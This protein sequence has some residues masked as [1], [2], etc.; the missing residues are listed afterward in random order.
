MN[1]IKRH[2]IKKRRNDMEITDIL[3]QETLDAI[4][5]DA[6]ASGI[7]AADVK[8]VLGTLTDDTRAPSRSA[9][10]QGELM[11]LLDDDKDA[12][13]NDIADATGVER[14][15]TGTILMLAAPFLLKYL[16]SSG[17]SN[18]S[19]GSNMSMMLP[20]LMA[21]MGG[22]QQQSSGLGL[23]GSLLGGGQQYQQ[24]QP[25]SLLGALLG[26]GQQY[27]Q[28]QQNSL[29]SSLLGAQP[30]QQSYSHNSTSALL[31][32][33]WAASLS[34]RCRRSRSNRAVFSTCSAE[35]ALSLRYSSLSRAPA[36]AC[37]APCSTSW[38]TTERKQIL[39]KEAF[40]WKQATIGPRAIKRKS[41]REASASARP[42]RSIPTAVL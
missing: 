7:S 40:R 15:K 25:G 2:S 35:T 26:G 30:Q 41:D 37:S 42:K 36:A 4:Y 17:S 6:A 13:V 8:A 24:N 27:Q 31:S 22:G 19:S 33:R 21:L 16:F 3:D 20:L 39:R 28:P 29:F 18:N 11:S 1:T 38:A 9:N 34:S 12:V 14:G 23:L 5:A 32:S 10:S